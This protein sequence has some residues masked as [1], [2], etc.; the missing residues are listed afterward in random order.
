MDLIDNTRIK[1]KKEHLISTQSNDDLIMM[2]LHNGDYIH[3]E[4]S[5][6]DIWELIATDITYAELIE[7]FM[8]L[9]DVSET[10]CRQD[11]ALFLQQL[12]DQNMLDL[13]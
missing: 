7:Q 12:N 13:T 2:N 1:R 4:K 8:I 11:I 6:V 3:M 10:E 5:A 9:Y